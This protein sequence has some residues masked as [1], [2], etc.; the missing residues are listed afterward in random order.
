MRIIRV[1][2]LALSVA[3]YG[4]ASSPSIEKLATNQDV[5]I[6][7][8]PVSVF[9]MAP[10]DDMRSECV[11]YDE[12]S[13]LKHCTLNNFNNSAVGDALRDSNLFE[14]VRLADKN[15]D[16]AVVI[17]TLTLVS[18]D[19][20]DFANA[21]VSGV[22]LFVVPMVLD[23]SVKS[24]VTLFWRGVPIK[25]YSYDFPLAVTNSLFNQESI[26]EKFAES[27]VSRFLEDAQNDDIFSGQFLSS[28]LQASNY[29]SNLGLPG[30]IDNYVYE[31]TFVYRDPFLGVNIRYQHQTDLY[32]YND[33]FVYPIRATDWSDETKILQS[34]AMNVRKEIELLEKEK[35]IKVL[36]FNDNTSVEIPDGTNKR[37]GLMFSCSWTNENGQMIVSYIYL[38]MS[39]DKFIKVRGSMPDEF[40]DY[41]L[42]DFVKQV[43]TSI[44]VPDEDVFMAKI[45]QQQ[46]QA[47]FQVEQ[48]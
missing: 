14:S 12:S 34:E 41:N 42:D 4:C 2:C 29:Q 1:I 48:P 39:K 37:T 28:A 20:G 9:W 47:M 17:N 11:K 7:Y 3:V 31:N 26:D 33:V 23:M 32:V 30:R 19:G 15:N 43:V 27:L 46:R 10:S 35:L 38:F 44:Q 6:K 18:E 40:E 45:R 5:E 16:Y 24:E 22:S 8:P 13:M 36:Q 25:Q 21:L